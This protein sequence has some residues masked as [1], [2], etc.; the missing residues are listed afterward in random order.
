MINP[1]FSIQDS[2]AD[3]LPSGSDLPPS[4]STPP[5]LDSQ[6][7]QLHRSERRIIPRLRGTLL[8]VLH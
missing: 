2:G 7:S 3:L 4:G 8:R 5:E 6:G 1:Y